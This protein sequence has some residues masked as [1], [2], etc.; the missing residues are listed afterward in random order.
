MKLILIS[1]AVFTVGCGRPSQKIS[2]D[3]GKSHITYENHSY[4]VFE[5]FSGNLAF[6]GV[7]HN[8]KCQCFK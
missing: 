3:Y 5:R 7:V 6:A 1:L 8:P 2:E 4:I